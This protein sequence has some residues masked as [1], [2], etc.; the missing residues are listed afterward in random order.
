MKRK[1]M[2]P[3]EFARQYG[4]ALTYV[5]GLLNTGRLEGWREDGRWHIPLNPKRLVA[6]HGPKP[7]ALQA[8]SN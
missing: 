1:T 5:Y 8:G 4:Y 7:R 6:S 2:S 3:T